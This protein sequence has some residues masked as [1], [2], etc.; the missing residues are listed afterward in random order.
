MV[1]ANAYGHGIEQVVKCLKDV[2]DF[3]GVAR[4]C[5]AEKIKNILPQSNILVVAETD[6][7]KVKQAA[8]N[9]ITLTISSLNE[10]K[11]YNKELKNSNNVLNIHIKI[12][13]GMNRLGVKSLQE[14]DNMLALLKESNNI[15]LKGIYTHFADCNDIDFT[16]EQ[17]NKFIQFVKKAKE[18][19]KNIIAHCA[20]STAIFTDKKY[21]LD[22]IRPGINLYGAETEKAQNKG[23]TLKPTMEV[24]SIVQTIKKAKKGESIGYNRA[25][26][27]KKD[28]FYAVISAGYGDGY[29]RALSNCGIININGYDCKIAGNICMDLF[30]A[31]LPQKAQKEIKTGDKAILLSNNIKATT[32]ENIS[33]LCNTIT[34]EILT[35]FTDRVQRI[36]KW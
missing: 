20:S 24:Y 34:Y 32:I 15:N 23:I 9:N 12:D 6:I 30:M 2:C 28:T 5:E 10:L 26:K 21:H 31:I 11:Q 16:K 19:N 17:Y 3:F 25:Y 22:M 4:F 13:S 1:K 7:K 14:L 18:F 33:K 27:V 35:S 29:K 36:Y 8:K